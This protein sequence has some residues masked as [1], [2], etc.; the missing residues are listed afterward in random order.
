M[1]DKKMGANGIKLLQG[2]EKLKNKMYDADGGGHCTVGWGHLVHKGK[3]DGRENEK[4]IN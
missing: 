1:A 4:A 3:C 2:F